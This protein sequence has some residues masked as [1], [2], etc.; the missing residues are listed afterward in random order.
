MN[1]MIY[2][3]KM[4]EPE[5]NQHHDPGTS[6]EEPV[7]FLEDNILGIGNNNGMMMAGHP[8]CST[9][10]NNPWMASTGTNTQV[11]QLY[12]SYPLNGG[13]GGNMYRGND[14]MAQETVGVSGNLDDEVVGNG[15]YMDPAIDLSG[16]NYNPEAVN[17]TSQ[18]A[19]N[20]FLPFNSTSSLNS[21]NSTGAINTYTS[22]STLG[23]EGYSAPGG[24]MA[25]GG[26]TTPGY[27]SPV[28]HRQSPLQTQQKQPKLKVKTEKTD[29][30]KRY[31]IIRG[32]SAGGC[33]TRPPKYLVDSNALYLP[34]ELHVNGAS[35]EEICFPVWS[36]SEKEDR[37]RII[38]IER[39]QNGHKLLANFSIVGAA[40][41][42]PITLPP[43]PDTD[44]IEVS[45]LECTTISN[46]TDDQS[47]SDED[48]AV[49]IQ[50]MHD[51]KYNQYYITSVEV[52]EIVELLIGTQSMDAADRRKERGRIRSNLVPFWSRKPISSRMPDNSSAHSSKSPGYAGMDTRLTN[53]DYRF[54]LAKRI[55]AYEI[56]KPRGFDKEVRILRWDKLIPALKRALQTYYTEIPSSDSSIDFS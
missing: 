31:R 21:M 9:T 23:S 42:N 22:A 17:T 25:P 6:Y 48:L 39:V 26:S 28:S 7:E 49:P 16:Y 41:E 14:R 30:K 1:F 36:A 38:R 20:L 50:G 44:V 55:M 40:N 45:C 51:G 47:A 5:H 24:P 37:R 46:E 15:T 18:Y 32:V 8:N 13:Y 33:S 12:L 34:I 10:L 35:F 54:E 29:T 53:Q 43:P 19:Q 27:P 4:I 52:I 11:A 3:N 2:G 56:R